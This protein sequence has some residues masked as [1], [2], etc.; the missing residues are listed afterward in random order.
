M[1]NAPLV[2]VL[3][4]AYNREKYIAEAIESVLNSTFT[5]FEVIVVDDGSSDKTVEIIKKY[6]KKDKRLKVYLNPQNIG[7]FHNRNKA[8]SYSRGKYLKYLDSDDILYPGSLEIMVNA[9]EK[10]PDVGLG[11]SGKSDTTLLPYPF[12]LNE[13]QAYLEH[14]W[15]SQFLSHGPGAAIYKKSVFLKAGMFESNYGILADTHLTLK[16]AALAPTIVFQRDLIFWRVHNAQITIEQKQEVRMVIE[17]YYIL[18]DILKKSYCPLKVIEVQ[19][20]LNAF[21][22]INSH[23]FLKK[24]IKLQFIN[25]FEVYRKTE[26]SLSFLFLSLIPSKVARIFKIRAS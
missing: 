25:A 2:S 16:I 19:K 15:S 10:H 18:N 23:H 1:E 14:L 3:V 5:N 20:I 11:I 12:K 8:V 22:R 24:L 13:E 17:R 21:K 9:M 6:E 7:Q 26:L 4:T